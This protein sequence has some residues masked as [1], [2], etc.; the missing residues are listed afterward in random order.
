MIQLTFISRRER[1]TIETMIIN[2]INQYLKLIYGDYR[3]STETHDVRVIVCLSILK[4]TILNPE[5]SVIYVIM[6]SLMA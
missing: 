6:C 5:F 1:N 3:V 4:T 2:V